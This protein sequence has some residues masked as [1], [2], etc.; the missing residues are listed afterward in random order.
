[1][2]M[3]TEIIKI[4]ET[5]NLQRNSHTSSPISK[6]LNNIKNWTFQIIVFFVIGTLPTVNFNHEFG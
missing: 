3:I 6:V 1:M 5:P 4:D 2:L